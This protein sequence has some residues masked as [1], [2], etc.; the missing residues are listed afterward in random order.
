MSLALHCIFVTILVLFAGTRIRHEDLGQ[1][2][3][4]YLGTDYPGGQAGVH[5]GHGPAERQN[6][7]RRQAIGSHVKAIKPSPPDHPKTARSETAAA[8]GRMDDP[9]TVAA[10]PSRPRREFASPDGHP[11]DNP[12]EAPGPE[13]EGSGI[14]ADTVRTG[15]GASSLDG[16]WTFTGGGKASD[17]GGSGTG[18]GGPGGGQAGSNAYVAAQFA[19]IR[20][21]ILK[22]LVYPSEA[23]HVGLRGRVTVDFI[24]LEDGLARNIR[25]VESSGHDV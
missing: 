2:I 7:D 3:T 6:G 22:N 15:T 8:R 20:G 11:A 1:I 24:I 23:R 14:G 13:G 17:G 9:V 5:P 21:L 10:S 16:V 25:I 12:I 18:S 19:Y 4:V